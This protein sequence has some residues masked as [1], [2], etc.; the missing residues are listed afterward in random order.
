MWLTEARQEVTL[1]CRLSRQI[2]TEDKL[3][4][5]CELDEKLKLVYLVAGL[6]FQTGVDILLHVQEV[7][8]Q[9]PPNCLTHGRQPGGTNSVTVHCASV[10]PDRS[11]VITCDRCGGTVSPSA[12]GPPPRCS[13]CSSHRR[14]A[15]EGC[16]FPEPRP[17]WWR[18]ETGVN[19]EMKAHIVAYTDWLSH[20]C[21]KMNLQTHCDKWRSHLSFLMDLWRKTHL[22]KIPWKA[23]FIL[24]ES[25]SIRFPVE[26]AQEETRQNGFY[27]K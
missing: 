11:P 12:R 2:S 1:L 6:R 25:K 19:G 21:V 9:P 20:R 3:M 13:G 4:L 27:R 24:F 5:V 17:R 10:R 22:Q 26:A 7:L 23:T 8:Q 18:R 14:W 15:S 16:A